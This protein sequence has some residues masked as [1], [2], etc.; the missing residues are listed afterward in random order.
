[1]RIVLF[2]CACIASWLLR[3]CYGATD[4]NNNDETTNNDDAEVFCP[5]QCRPPALRN[6]QQRQDGGTRIFYLVIVHNEQSMNDAL[7]LLRAIR[8]PR[9]IIAIHVDF[10]ARHLL[11]ASLPL[12]REIESC[13]CGSTIRIEAVHNVQ[14]SQWSMNLPTFWGMQLAV[15]EF[16]QQ[17]DVF[18]N[19]AGN[20]LPVYTA[21]TMASILH[22]LPYNFVT[23]SSC[24][25]GLIPTNVYQFPHYWHKRRHYTLD[26]TEPDPY[27]FFSDKQGRTRNETLEIHF[28]SQWVILQADFCTW[29]VEE[30]KRPDS[31][32]FLLAEHL[33]KSGRKMTDETFLPTLL[34]YADGFNTTLPKTDDDQ[35]LLWRNGTTSGI[36]DIRFERMD[37]HVPTA[38]GQFWTQQRYDVPE[39]SDVENPKVWGPYYLGVYDLANIRASGALFVRKISRSIDPNMIRLLPVDS[40][41]D[42]PEIQ[43]PEEV[44]LTEKP[45]WKEKV[46]EA[47]E[48]AK[49]AES[50]EEADDEEL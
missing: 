50:E 25:T 21:N 39:A 6:N 9:N 41:Q 22:E 27:I 24:E 23:S 13:P 47:Y 37:E 30:M 49:Q 2:A 29:F 12:Q 19:L 1:M 20:T 48:A 10:K 36:S 33:Q 4:N 46:R 44:L 43:W 8:D 18:I 32:A 31:L 16:A 17:W 7:P 40:R 26:E 45:N 5:A 34:M 42:I 28:G 38:F 14:W 35:V 11:D 3:T 15:E